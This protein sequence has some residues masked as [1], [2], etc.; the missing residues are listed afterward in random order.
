MNIQ[1]QSSTTTTHLTA[2]HLAGTPN[3]HQSF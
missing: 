2:D 1:E 3:R